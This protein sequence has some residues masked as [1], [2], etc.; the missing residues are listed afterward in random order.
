[1]LEVIRPPLPW[2]HVFCDLACGTAG[3]NRYLKQIYHGNVSYIAVDRSHLAISL[4]RQKFPSATFHQLDV[5]ASGI[6]LSPLSCDSLVCNG[7]FAEKWN[8]TQDAMWRCIEETITR[9][10]GLSFAAESHSM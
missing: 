5:S 3:L 6:D 9:V 10:R 8:L 2:C 1:M 7:L 4:A